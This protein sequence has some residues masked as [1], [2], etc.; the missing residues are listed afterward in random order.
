[1]VIYYLFLCTLLYLRDYVRFYNSCDT[2]TLYTCKVLVIKAIF[3]LVILEA[4]QNIYVYHMLFF[5]MYFIYSNF[6]TFCLFNVW[7]SLLYIIFT[8]YNLISRI[9]NT[10]THTYIPDSHVLF[11]FWKISV[12]LPY[13]VYCV[14]YKHASMKSKSN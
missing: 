14:S 13:I 11:S 3:I 4:I 9:I 2:C 1:M 8:R 5:Q 6:Q 7:F 12:R 10:N